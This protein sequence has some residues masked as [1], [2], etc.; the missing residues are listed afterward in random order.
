M[1]EKLQD[2]LQS[3]KLKNKKM[4]L[5][6]VAANDEEVLA[7][8]SEAQKMG[9]AEVTL[10]GNL[11]EIQKIAEEH[12]IDIAGM[13]LIE[14]HS[15]EEAAEKGVRLVSSGKANVIMKG[16]IDTSIF[17]KAVLNKDWGLRTDSLLSHVM[18]YDVPTYH[19]LLALTDGG[20]LLYPNVEEKI[21]LIE[22]AA[23]VMRSFGRDEIKVACLAAKEKVNPKMPPT[24]DADELKKRFEQGHFSEGIV[25]D[26]P[27]ALDLAVSKESARIKGFESTVAGDA[28]ILL[29]PSIE[30]GNG[31]GKSL[32]YF[33]NAKSAGVVMGA[34][35]P[36]VL[37]SRADD[38]ETKLY[39]VALG[40]I[41]A[42]K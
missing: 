11:R 42:G 7:A 33:A 23:N 26:G 10:V 2:L 24:V 28:D 15:L 4:S 8:V 35:C 40:G 19:K 36:I 29:V 30:M 6:I 1:I 12:E 3:E 34:K 14:T 32:T 17:L 41:V 31:I 27:L 16:L 13:E 5:S 37:T 21:K 20:M 25:V 9:I 39:S 22:N 18:V 38:H